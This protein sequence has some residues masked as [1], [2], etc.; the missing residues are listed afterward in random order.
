MTKIGTGLV[1]A[2]CFGLAV[3]QA[4]AQITIDVSKITCEQ[5]R[6]YSVTDPNNIALWLSGYYNGQRRN[7][8]IS[9]TS[10][11]EN[12]EKVMDYC[13][14]N[15]KMTVMHAVETILGKGN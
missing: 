9:V 14:T 12:L 5:F 4:Q 7:T 3:A 13:I 8:V 15:Q 10:F 2:A 1:A 6:N 11:K